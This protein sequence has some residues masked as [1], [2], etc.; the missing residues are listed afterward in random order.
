MTQV[1]PEAQRGFA[2]EVVERLRRAGH[3]AYW[4]GGCVRDRLLGLKPK[5]YDI[6][7]AARPDEIRALFG[8]RRTLAIGAAFGVITVLGPKPAGQIEVATFR[9][10]LG[11]TDGRR[12][13]AVEF[14]TAEEDARRRD[15][16]I[17]GLFFDP[18]TD[19]V[20]DFVEG[21]ADLEG[22]LIRAIGEPEERFAE[23]KL[24]LLRAVRFAARF[25]FHL[26][27]RSR[28]A[29]IAMAPEI[30]LVS[31]ERIAAEL[32]TMFIG[33]RPGVALRMLHETGL[34]AAVLPELRETWGE[35]GGQA[36]R[37]AVARALDAFTKLAGAEFPTMFAALLGD[38]I[39]SAAARELCRRLKLPN[40][41]TDRVAWLLEHRVRLADAQR[42]PWPPLQRVLAQAGAAELVAL[43]LATEKA[44]E[45]DIEFCRGVLGQPQEI[46][47]PAPLVTG[48]DL[49][50]A[51]IPGG[52]HFQHLLD[53][54]RDAQ[55]EQ[56][57]A[58]LE[59]A[60]ALAKNLWSNYVR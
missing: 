59:A 7:T 17:N 55:L 3:E 20:L 1:D 5:D 27:E 24:R 32:R 23:D 19:R 46:W 11:Y 13:D 40:R 54:V 45:A 34:L 4:A 29:M 26:D 2:V 14:S 56:R 35:A 31:V 60:L 51:G 8:H 53:T 41:D 44:D 50:R 49:L 9:R 28:R 43:A 52:K 22:K 15:F 25:D 36:E 38:D 16:T 6:A 33:P 12:P 37:R 47:N 21:A 42:Q 18:V 48:N 58:T 57:I 10:D 30:M 39:S